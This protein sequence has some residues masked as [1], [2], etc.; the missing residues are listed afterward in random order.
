[1]RR[2]RNSSR[3][4]MTR[5]TAR[6]TI[7]GQLI[8][9]WFNRPE[10]LHPFV[11]ETSDGIIGYAILSCDEDRAWLTAGL[12]PSDRGHGIGTRVFRWL[13]KEA[14]S[15]D[16]LPC[17]EVRLSNERARKVY[18]NLGFIN[19]IQRGEIMMMEKRWE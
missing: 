8:W 13:A 5:D 2:A 7:V 19:T 14:E 12:L 11:V 6:K 18:R 17:L 3:K 1:M 9:W 4:Y 10:S 16:L 15:M